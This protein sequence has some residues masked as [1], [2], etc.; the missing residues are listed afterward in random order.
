[1]KLGNPT[2]ADVGRAAGLSAAAVS[3]ALRGK[4]GVSPATRDRVLAVAARLGYEPH[5]V[6]SL[7]AQQRASRGGQDRLS[8]GYLIEPTH[9]DAYFLANCEALGLQGYCIRPR[10]FSS[11]EAASQILW[12]RGIAGLVLSDYGM[13]WSEE[14]RR[15]FNWGLFSVVKL[16]RGLPDLPFHLVRH[17]AFDY[18]ATT[19]GQVVARGYRRI[20]VLPT[21]SGST[22]DDDARFGA[23]LN[24]Q[25]RKLP[26]GVSLAWT[27]EEDAEALRPW[28]SA[29]QP[30]AIVVLVFATIYQLR[31]MGWEFPGKVGLAAVLGSRER[32]KG[33]PMVSGCDFRTADLHRRALGMLADLIGR[34]ERGF[35]SHPTEGV[36]GPEWIEGETLPE[37]ASM[38]RRG[39]K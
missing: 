21:H 30:D 15:R 25:A 4:T 2:L 6:A 34:G 39:K 13:P 3:M 12:N 35:V 1:M 19:L 20:A 28:L 38:H 18:M 7:L 29:T 22:M 8:V 31:E 11:P 33:I 5:R 27:E 9:Q 16:S 32:F 24:F 14:E 26:P 36:I 17:S 10:E 23:L 37:R